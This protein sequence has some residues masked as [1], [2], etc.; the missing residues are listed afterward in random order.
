MKKIVVII[1]LLFISIG[2]SQEKTITLDYAVDYLVT[3]NKQSRIDTVKVGLDKSGTYLWTDSKYLAK[4][5]A[6]SM[7]LGKDSLLENSELSIIL[8]TESNSIMLFF[9]SEGNELYMNMLLSS[10]FPDSENGENKEFDFITENTNDTILVAGKE[11]EIYDIYP[12]NEG[13]SQKISIAF[14]KTLEVDNN[15]LFRKFLE[16]IF[17]TQNG[18]V[19]DEMNFPNGLILDITLKGRKLIEANNIEQKTKTI[20]INHSFKITE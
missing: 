11:A 15:Q 1:L 2:F 20:T 12:S 16:L 6:A 19:M 14:D 17:A 7:F 9:N 5:L 4:N 10:F 18:L 13:E 8:D 3:N